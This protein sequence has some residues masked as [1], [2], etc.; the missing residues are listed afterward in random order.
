MTACSTDFGEITGVAAYNGMHLVDECC[1]S[2]QPKC[3][4]CLEDGNTR[5]FCTMIGSC[6][7]ECTRSSQCVTCMAK[8]TEAQCESYGL[9][10]ACP[11]AP[12]SSR[13]RA[14][15]ISAAVQVHANPQS[16]K[17][18]GTVLECLSKKGSSASVC[19]KA[20]VPP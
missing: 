14:Q 17:T 20:S 16:V 4:T 6:H 9:H 13:R 15:G 19:A 2:C 5:T 12:S 7:T 3:A 18:L 11:T 10:C 8:R 1:A